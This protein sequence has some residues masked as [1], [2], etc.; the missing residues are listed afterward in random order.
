MNPS[1]VTKEGAMRFV[2]PVN[3]AMMMVDAGIITPEQVI[4]S[5]PMPVM[6][7]PK[8]DDGLPRNRHE[9]RRQAARQRRAA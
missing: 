4:L 5:Q 1:M 9:R 6:D 8:C 7:I 3:K 2:L